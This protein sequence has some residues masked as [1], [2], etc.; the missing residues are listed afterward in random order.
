MY[1]LTPLTPTEVKHRP[2]HVVFLDRL[3]RRPGFD[4][5]S[6]HNFE[7][8]MQEAGIPFTRVACSHANKTWDIAAIRSATVL[9]GATGAAF[10]NTWHLT[11]G[12][13]VVLATTGSPWFETW[14]FKALALNTGSTFIRWTPSQQNYSDPDFGLTTMYPTQ[15][16]ATWRTVMRTALLQ[17]DARARSHPL[18]VEFLKERASDSAPQDRRCDALLMVYKPREMVSSNTDKSVEV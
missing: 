13:V 10:T 4:E 14:Y 8:V 5:E 9:I 11:P 1:R 17:Q 15:S 18:A 3:K 7:V 6:L 12:A 2:A 16:Q